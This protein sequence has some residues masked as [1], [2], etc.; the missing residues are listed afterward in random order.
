[1]FYETIFLNP[2]RTLRVNQMREMVQAIDDE[3][4]R[5]QKRETSE[6]AVFDQPQQLQDMKKQHRE[7]RRL[8]KQYIE[9]LK[10]D[11]EVSACCVYLHFWCMCLEQ[12]SFGKKY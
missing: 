3:A 5:D 1:M 9:A 8:G 11:Q 4:D 10:R 6:R 7:Q 12:N 2:F